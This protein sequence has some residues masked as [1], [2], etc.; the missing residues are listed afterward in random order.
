MG[1]VEGRGDGE[2]RRFEEEPAWFHSRVRDGYL[3]QAK[4]DPERWLVVDGILPQEQVEE[5]IWRRVEPLVK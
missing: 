4:A 2:G 1:R 3:V 5:I